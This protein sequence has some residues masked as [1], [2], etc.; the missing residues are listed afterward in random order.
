MDAIKKL[1]EA[2]LESIGDLLGEYTFANGLKEKAIAVDIGGKYPPKG[3]QITGL[4]CVIVPQSDLSASWLLGSGVSLQASHRI[5]LKQWDF[6]KPSNQLIIAVQRLAVVFGSDLDIGPRLAPID[7]L[8]NIESCSM[9]FT[10][11]EN[12]RL[13]RNG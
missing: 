6:E 3:T 9:I 1:R 10:N 7:E 4:E 11:Y 12:R 8:G 2:I 5:E 13:I